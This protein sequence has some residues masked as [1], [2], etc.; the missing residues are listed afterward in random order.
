MA[1]HSLCQRAKPQANSPMTNQSPQ[2]Y[3]DFGEEKSSFL[4]RFI[5]TIL[6]LGILTVIGVVS[7]SASTNYAQNLHEVQPAKNTVVEPILQSERASQDGLEL[8]VAPPT[9]VIEETALP[10]VQSPFGSSQPTPRPT[11]AK[12]TPKIETSAPASPLNTDFA[13]IQS[14]DAIL[15][16]DTERESDEA[17][18]QS[19]LD[20]QN[21]S[22]VSPAATLAAPVSQSPVPVPED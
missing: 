13:E 1:P 17:A 20:T 9:N 5:F 16:A 8:M 21:R 11:T 3:L 22:R 10:P 14:A 18:A 4:S 2:T 12:L 6:G 15:P 7:Y 19:Q